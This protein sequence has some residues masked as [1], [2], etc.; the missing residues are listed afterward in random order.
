MDRS[1]LHVAS[2]LVR[3]SSHERSTRADKSAEKLKTNKHFY[4]STTNFRFIEYAKWQHSPKFTVFS[5]CLPELLTIS[6]FGNK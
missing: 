3:D 5:G 6:F 2:R 1:P 4:T